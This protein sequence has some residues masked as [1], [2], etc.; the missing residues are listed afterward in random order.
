M[1]GSD[2]SL[3]IRRSSERERRIGYA[4]LAALAYIPVLLAHTGRVVADT[5][6]Y[7]YLDPGRVLSR[8]WAMWDANIGMGT[9]THQNIGYLFPMGPYYWAME[10]LGV[11]DWVAQRIWLG[12]IL[13]AAGLGMLY[14][15]RTLDLRGAGAPVGALV[16]VLSP[17]WLEYAARLS[18]LLLPWAG[19]PWMLAFLIRGLRRG[20]WRHAALFALLIQVIGSVNLTA[21]VFAGLAPVLW[22]PYA[23]FVDRE[24][25]WRRVLSIVGK[26]GVLTLLASAWWISGLWAQGAYGLNILK[27]TE[28]MS[29][30]SR[31]TLPNEVLRGLGYWFFYGRDRLGPWIEASTG[32]TQHPALILVSYAIPTLAFLSA[33]LVRWRHRT[34]FMLVIVVGAVVAVGAHPYASPTPLGG[35][36]KRLSQESSIAFALRSTGRAV[37]LVVLGLAALIGAGVTALVARAATWSRPRVAVAI[38]LLVGVLLFLN[39]PALWT[40]GFYGD[41]LQRPEEIPT[42][43]KQAAQYLDGAGPDTRVLEVPGSDFGSYR[44]GQTVDPITPGIIDRPYVAREVIPYGS[45]ASANLLN[46]FD[47]RL[48]ERQLT[49]DAIAPL[50]RLM[51]VGAI[52]LRNDIQFERYRLLRPQFTSVLFTPTPTGLRDPVSFG[53]ATSTQST[54][55]PFLDEQ[56]ILEPGVLAV[57]PPVSVYDVKQPTPIMRTAPAARP[58][59]MAGDGEGVVDAAEIGLIDA[60]TALLYSGSYGSDARGLRREIARDATLVVTDSNRDRGRRWSS[61]TETAGFTEG[62]GSHPLRRDE[63]DSRLDLF[64]DAAP[65]A[66]TITRLVGARSVRADSYGNAISYT[67]EDRPARAFDS[68]PFTSWRVGQFDEVKGKRIRITLDHRI[69]TDHVN[70]VQVLTAPNDRF[71]TDATLRFDGGHDTPIRL[72]RTSRTE[73]GETIR[74]PRRTFSTFEIEVRGTNVGEQIIFGGLSPVGFGEIR[75]TDAAGQPV[76][77]QEVVE[78]PKDLLRIAGAA[79]ATRPLVLLM[80]RD[81]VTPIPARVDPEGALVRGFTVPTERSFAVAAD[82]RLARDRDDAAIDRTL[83]YRGPVVATSSARLLGAP[84]VRASAALDHDPATAWTTPFKTAVGSSVHLDF[85]A[86]RTLDHLALDLVADG[87]HSVPTALEIRTARGERRAVTLDVP[88]DLATPNATVPVTATFPAVSGRELDIRITK[89]RPVL[90]REYDCGCDVQTPA[91]IAELRIPGLAAVRPPAAMPVTCRD[92]LISVDGRPV[93]AA[94]VGSTAD[95]V[96]LR[97]LHL[98]ICTDHAAPVGIQLAAGDHQVIGATGAATGVVVD[99]LVWSSSANGAASDGLAVDGSVTTDPA[100]GAP[101]VKVLR[102]GRVRTTAEVAGATTPFWFV[103]GQS[104]NAGWHASVDGKDLGP[105]TLVDGYAN[106]WLITPDAPTL[107]IDLEW[108]PERTVQ[109]SIALSVVAIMVCLGIVVFSHTRSRRVD[110]RALILEVGGAPTLDRPAPSRLPGWVTSAVTAAIIGGA[111]AIVVR[112]VIGIVLGVVALGAMRDRRIRRL[113]DLVPALTIAVAGG[114][115]AFRQ[116]RHHLPPIFEWPTLFSR[117]RTLGWIAIVVLGANAVIGLVLDRRARSVRPD[118][119]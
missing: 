75:L 21:L 53:K 18:V 52:T 39:L 68:D 23:L 41:N 5:K 2:T 65:D 98:A 17:Y 4:L 107:S 59:I 82:V 97:P 99:R 77:V 9:V 111:G 12:S 70:L 10:H 104:D 30:V 15:F 72:G 3:R 1:S 45:P 32:Y 61:L 92:D 89:V 102:S 46:A 28:T 113:L 94:I 62:P 64:P 19:L 85:G 90:T 35:A 26:I 37:P 60:G 80:N 11:P 100:V 86:V 56:A 14:L 79:S 96:A 66:Q 69:T 119:G 67:P 6:Q 118:R 27:Y 106:G 116:A 34:Y 115:I 93:P 47:L 25:D 16:F 114:Y 71:I 57:P 109:R 36:F 117:A 95:A 24:V 101:A 73:A 112:P 110:L 31:T 29:V 83:G 105:S 88:P 40:G 50:A 22:I 51:G 55:F 44:W 76:R 38:P 78:M 58:V 103:L 84:A 81:R 108:V 48:Q 91:A 42:Y 87:R 54:E 49:P 43:W 13:F 8:A 63:S 33:A 7:L 74:F 20:G